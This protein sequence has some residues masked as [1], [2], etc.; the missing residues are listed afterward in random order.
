LALVHLAPG[1]ISIQISHLPHG[2]ALADDPKVLAVPT[3]LA[4]DSD[5]D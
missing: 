1:S 2:S 5:S 4:L 3:L